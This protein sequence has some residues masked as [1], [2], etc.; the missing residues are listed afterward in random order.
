MELK[1]NVTVRFFCDDFKTEKVILSPTSA[2]PVSAEGLV[3]HRA[4]LRKDSSF[5]AQIYNGQDLIGRIHGRLP[6]DWSN[7]IEWII[8]GQDVIFAIF[9]KI[10]FSWL[11]RK[12][13]PPIQWQFDLWYHFEIDNS[14]M[15]TYKL[16]F[17]PTPSIDV[18]VKLEGEVSVAI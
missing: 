7:P 8:E 3:F 9:K 11:I 12:F 1:N 10:P 16:H 2:I 6:V 17:G 4:N 5:E 14:G 15:L 18:R 13:M